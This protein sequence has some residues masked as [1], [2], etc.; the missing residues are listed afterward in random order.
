[1]EHLGASIL[2]L[3]RHSLA[4]TM[5]TAAQ[6]LSLSEISRSAAQYRAR[7]SSKCS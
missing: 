3:A 2:L 4:H 7:A 1:M 5:V 6:A